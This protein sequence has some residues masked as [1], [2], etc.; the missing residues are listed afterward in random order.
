MPNR[1]KTT[2]RFAAAFNAS[3]YKK[4]KTAPSNVFIATQ[5]NLRAHGT[6][7]VSTE[8]VRK[9]SKGL[10]Y[11]SASHLTAIVDWLELNPNDFLVDLMAKHQISPLSEGVGKDDA[12]LNI[13]SSQ[14]IL[15]SLKLEIAVVASSGIIVQVNKAW[16]KFFTENSINRVAETFL[17]KNYLTVCDHTLG[18][19]DLNA[20]DMVSGIRKVLRGDLK[21]FAL[22]YACHSPQQK[23]WFIGRVSPI[24][25]NGR[26]YAVVS[27]QVISGENSRKAKL[28]FEGEE[29]AKRAG[30][31]VI[32]NE[33]K[34]ARAAE[35]VI[36]NTELLFEGEEKAKRA[37]EL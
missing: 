21:E 3:L 12:N 36:A 19:E 10:A 30:E 18:S 17:G 33:D 6:S 35:L 27:H 25:H 13:I 31:L 26:I 15:D 16:I 20:N 37:G 2:Q 9:W 32:A 11:P 28:L 24:S 14:Q 5:F 23:C 4:Y 7:T 22:K 8:T 34:A 1:H 29:K